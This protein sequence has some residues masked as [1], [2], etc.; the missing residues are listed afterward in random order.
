VVEGAVLLD[1][2][3]HRL[4]LARHG[5]RRGWDWKR[6]EEAKRSRMAY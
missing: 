3:H 5:W 4:D 2:H 1:Q 6:E